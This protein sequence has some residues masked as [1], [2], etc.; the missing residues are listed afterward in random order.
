M[1]Q[2]ALAKVMTQNRRIALNVIATYGR[3][4]Y[5]MACG[6]LTSRWALLALGQVDLGLYGVIGGLTLFVGL[7]N[8]LMAGAVSRFYAYS[9]G[10]SQK[11][12]GDREG[13]DECVH[14]FN[15]ACSIHFVLPA[16][17]LAIGYPCGIWAINNFLTIPAERLSDSIWVWR[18]TC[19]SA[20]VGMMTVPFS[21]MY[22][23]KQEIAELT[24]YGVATT[25]LNFLA[26][27]YMVT[28]PGI[29]LK[30]YAL[31][32]CLTAALPLLIVA[33]RAVKCYPECKFV[34]KYMWDPSRLKRLLGYAGATAFGAISKI[35][36]IQGVAIL[37][38]KFLGPAKNAT[39]TIGN[40]VANHCMTLSGSFMGALRPAITNAIGAGKDEYARS[41]AYRTCQ[42]S[43]LSFLV[44]MLPLA[45]EMDYVLKLWLK[46]PPDGLSQLCCLM[47]AGFVLD[48][49]TDGHW[50]VVLGY[51]KIL[52]YQIA[53]SL[54]VLSTFLSVA[55]FMLLGMG[56]EAVGWGMICAKIIRLG[57]NLFYGR[58]LGRLSIRRWGGKI[59]LPLISVSMIVLI[60][61]YFL[62]MTMHTGFCRL[63][64]VTGAMEVVF[65]PLV[66][67][68]VL[69][70]GSRQL[71]RQKL[72]PL[73][74]RV[75]NMH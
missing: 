25:T 74:G 5:A 42:L 44:F 19:V 17:L 57:V 35:L 52:S 36:S 65:I 49:L 75:F 40:S 71:I 26:V 69:E 51:G 38:N 68:C 53:E 6:L 62:S 48:R 12:G 41:L 27:Y 39:L 7:L 4:L 1:P 9:V 24:I 16:I 54:A 21:A 31:C 45:V 63:M 55:V 47:L 66:W 70:E 28:H 46:T 22:N 2:V 67:L 8:S 33:F 14:W 29:W 34:A 3:S 56:I 72:E 50:M 37:V 60:F 43:G 11:T 18:F 73:C 32:M 58:K 13:L 20:G 59:A 10:Q 15:V 61:G 23:A 64:L 30:K